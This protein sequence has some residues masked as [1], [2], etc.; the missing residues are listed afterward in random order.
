MHHVQHFS[1]MFMFCCFSKTKHTEWLP[2]IV[3]SQPVPFSTPTRPGFKVAPEP[4][5]GK[6]PSIIYENDF[7][8]N[9]MPG[10]FYVSDLSGSQAYPS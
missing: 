7:N 5:Q 8:K 4:P 9:E 3:M 1:R 10:G 2:P 6:G